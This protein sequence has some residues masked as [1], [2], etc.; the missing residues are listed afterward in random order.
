MVTRSTHG[1]KT[2]KG[3]DPGPAA[4]MDDTACNWAGLVE[5]NLLTTLDKSLET[6]TI[7]RWEESG[8]RIRGSVRMASRA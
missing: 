7:G 4:T 5:I 3:R 2:I 8:N 1:P 6:G